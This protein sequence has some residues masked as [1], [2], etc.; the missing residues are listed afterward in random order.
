[1][2]E[3][4]RS[5]I[6]KLIR[7]GWVFLIAGLIINYIYRMVVHDISIQNIIMGSDM[8]GYY[9]YLVHFF[10]RDWSQFDRMPWT[11]P[12]GEGK[13]LSTFTCGVA[14]LCSPFFLMAHLISIFLGLDTSGFSNVYFGSIQVA[15]IVYTYIGLVFLYK[16][17]REFFDHKICLITVSLF[18]LSTN[19]FFYSVLIGAGMSHVYSFSLITIY[20]YFSIQFS[21]KP[22]LKNLIYLGVPFALAILIRPTNVISGLFLIFYGVNSRVDLKS[23]F[24]FWLKNY[25]AIIGL[26][27][28]G[29]IVSSPQMAYWHFVTGKFIVFS[30]QGSSFPYWLAPKFGIVLFGKYNGWLLYT[31][32]AC[33]GLIGLLILLRRNQMNSAI[34]LLILFIAIYINASWCEPT[35][36]AAVGQ[37]AMIDFLPFLA[38]P[39]AFIISQ[40][41]GMSQPLKILL[42]LIIIFFIFYNIKFSFSYSAGTWWDSPMSWTKFWNALKF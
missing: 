38:I 2:G 30:Y 41:R 15:G 31:P 39:I 23:R 35:F 6:S 27:V 4:N 7:Y 26:F 33:F 40:I 34:A 18:F 22:S 28:I 1:M 12:Y 42:G 25:W 13:T 14:I 16:F 19:I 37:R 32:I 5:E 36:S 24:E 8:E 21:K 29:V 3:T 11:M 10:I 20:L 9:Q 17:L